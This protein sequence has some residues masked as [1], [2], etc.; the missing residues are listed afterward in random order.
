[1]TDSTADDGLDRRNVAD[2]LRRHARE[3][4]DQVALVYG[5]RETDYDTLDRQ[6]SAIANGLIAA[7]IRPS[8]RV[9]L[10]AKNSDDFIALY[11]GCAKAG[12]VLVPVNW[13]LA[14]PEMAYII[15]DSGA[16]V[17]VLGSGYHGM[18][19]E[20]RGMMP[21]VEL[22][23]AIDGKADGTAG[24]DDFRA[25]YGRQA[26]VDPMVRVLATDIAAQLYS[27]GTT[28]HP[29]G[30]QLSHLSCY[31]L[32][33][34]LSSDE[35]K[36]YGRWTAAD[37][38]LIC[39]P[40]YHVGGLNNAL[41]GLY[42]GARTVIMAEAVPA[43]ILRLIPRYRV[44]KSFMVP[45]LINFLLQTPGCSETD[46]SSIDEIWYGAAPIPAELLR[47]AIQVIGNKFGQ[48]YGMTESNGGGVY[49]SPDEHDLSKP[50]RLRAC[51]RAA[52]GY[53]LRVVDEAGN[54][55]PTGEVGEIIM[56]S[57]TMM[58]GYW[59]LPEA[60][61]STL[62]DG[63]LH[64]GDAGYF[65]DEQFLYIYDRVKDMVISGGENIYPAEVESALF[66]HPAIAD[67][68]IIGVPDER[69]G[70]AIKAVIVKKAGAEVTEAEVIAYARERIAH[71]KCPKSVD[72][73]AELPRNPTGKILKRELRKPYWEKVGRNVG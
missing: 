15:N 13:R 73:I 58:S 53:E 48:A 44:T 11:F 51:G 21:A 67:V 18:G 38:N 39:M 4:G 12:A 47:Q 50:E 23:L 5:D 42:V 26:D 34:I 62:K 32:W 35:T 61:A 20:H 56:R 70:E 72:F 57:A 28:G 24:L 16:R 49:M 60:T 25:W 2:V 9:G 52:P 40:L 54:D 17:L 3:T 64:T 14:E 36:A 19:L 65:D 1:M 45:A 41:A 66:G 27:S 59:N 10:I 46:F 31:E 30:V 55:V 71:Y 6:A 7:G 37:V 69:W 33:P 63:W 43:E 22:V 68:A 8:D 29:K